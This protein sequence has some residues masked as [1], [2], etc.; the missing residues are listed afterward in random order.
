MFALDCKGVKSWNGRSMRWWN[1][2]CAAFNCE[3]KSDRCNRDNRTIRDFIAEKEAGNDV[4]PCCNSILREI[5][6]IWF[7]EVPNNGS[8]A[9]F[10]SL[11]GSIR[12]GRFMGW[13][14][15]NDF[16]APNA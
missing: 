15:D 6:D 5:S 12:A 9:Y 7:S 1:V 4:V 16:F 8:F 3:F 14:S 10:G 13:T 2:G 11:L